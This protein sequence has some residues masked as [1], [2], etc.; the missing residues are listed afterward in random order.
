MP[1]KINA[2]GLPAKK[3]KFFY[4]MNH[5]SFNNFVSSP[6][7]KSFMNHY[8]SDRGEHCAVGCDM[9]TS[10]LSPGPD[11][12]SDRS[13]HARPYKHT[14][15]KYGSHM[16]GLTTPS[17]TITPHPNLKELNKKLRLLKKDSYKVQGKNF[18][19]Y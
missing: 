7:P 10:L 14:R 9:Q 5:C 3:G 19:P 13:E 16:K 11:G 1:R 18:V 15:L 12:R 4:K 8:F 6:F 2:N 17:P